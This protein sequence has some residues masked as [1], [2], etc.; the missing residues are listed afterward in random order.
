MNRAHRRQQQAHIRKT[1]SHTTLR[2]QSGVADPQALKAQA[3]ARF[4]AG[5]LADSEQLC[6]QILHTLPQDGDTLHLLGVVRLK[7]RRAREAVSLLEQALHYN[8][9]Q[10]TCTRNLAHAHGAAGNLPQAIAT[11]RALL[12]LQDSTENHLLLVNLFLRDGEAEA[13]LVQLETLRQQFAQPISEVLCQSAVALMAL[14]RSAEAE[15]T[16]CQGLA[17]APGHAVMARNLAQLYR[18]QG[19]LEKART[20]LQDACA[21]SPAT[22]ELWTG[23]AALD[24][25]AGNPEGAIATLRQAIVR[26]PAHGG[27]YHV[28]ATLMSNAGQADAAL[29]LHRRAVRLEPLNIA[30][31]NSYATALTEA[32]TLPR[33]AALITDLVTLFALPKAN[34]IQALKIALVIL[35]TDPVFQALEQAPDSLAFARLLDQHAGSALFTGPLL[36]QML[37]SIFIPFWPCER[38]FSTLRRVLL[39]CAA[40]GNFNGLEV[41]LTDSL[42]YAL[43]HQ[44]FLNEYVW[45]VSPDE[46]THLHVLKQ[47]LRAGKTPDKRLLAL[48]G[49]YDSL[50]RLPRS[51]QLLHHP[52]TRRDPAFAFLLQRQIGEPLAERK[53]AASI[54]QLTPVNT[55]VSQAVQAMY[56]E[57][58]YPRWDNFI[59]GQPKGFAD[60]W[61]G[62]C[63]WLV[64]SS[65][66]PIAT[67]RI[68]IAGCGTGKH[69][70]Q[71]ASVF[72]RPDV[73]AVD[74][75]RASL[76]FARRKQ[77]ELNLQH[78]T[79]I[80]ADIL[81]LA[82]CTPPMLAQHF[83]DQQ[84]DQIESAGVLHHMA[85]PVAGWRVLVGL[86]KP[87]G[88]M[89]IALYSELARR[90]VV[91]AR[92]MVAEQG[93]GSDADSIRQWRQNVMQMPET[94][95][96]VPSPRHLQ[97]FSDFFSLSMCRDLAFHVQEHRFTLPQIAEILAELGLEFLGFEF[98]AHHKAPHLYADRFADD[99]HQLSLANWAQF[100]TKFPD[101]FRG[102]YQFCVRKECD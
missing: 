14:G 55:G 73:L 91:A 74:L 54:P 12:D 31:W 70:F 86:L 24:E 58:P 100:E 80:Q 15:G 8:A 89:K 60:Y 21:A 92:Q 66:A 26:I 93:Y 79:L 42:L 49:C 41:P 48:Y 20:V 39:Q 98:A 57:N 64:A 23:L 99:P 71:S 96:D 46:Q 97:V 37:Q 102:M 72:L 16:L 43:A 53:L 81:Q 84:F 9:H 67:P 87:G 61:R 52:E 82:D 33:D 62:Q 38:V 90:H 29:P 88:F 40:T 34:H 3:A 56:E 78:V 68:L 10:I 44:C 13:A 75:S 85:D 51:E 69:A 25:L 83:F 77:Q 22:P 65:I 17:L 2:G 4:Q 94:T 35:R 50:H 59:V 47:R 27:L 7:Q 18:A 28:L 63:P 30:F 95:S 6:T 36:P 45:W 1:T 5:A 32:K 101:T 11:A 19:N 76:A